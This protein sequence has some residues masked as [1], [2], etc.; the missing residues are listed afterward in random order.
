M[1]SRF[2][3]SF[4]AV[5]AAA[6][7]LCASAP[8]QDS[9]VGPQG[10]LQ[11]LEQWRADRGANWRV[12]VDEGT[13][14][15]EFLFGGSVAREDAPRTEADWFVAAREAL[16]LAGDLHGIESSTLVEHWTQ[17]LPLGMV[18]S[19][20]KM[21][22]RFAQQ[23]DGVPVDGGFVNVLFD[24][25]GTLLS[26]QTRALPAIV[27]MD[28]R[29]ALTG[30]LGA[31]FARTA[32]HAET[33]LDG[34]VVGEPRLVIAQVDDVESRSGVLAW[35]VEVLWEHASG[36][37]Q[38]GVYFIDARSGRVVRHE[39][40][41]HN[42]DISGNVKSLASPGVLPDTGA[43]PESAQNLKYTRVTAGAVTT[44]TDANGNFTLVGVNAPA[45]VT[46]G[47]RG[48]YNNISNSAGATYSLVTTLASATGNNVVLNQPATDLVTSQANINIAVN[49]DRDF[50]RATN[51]T[52][53]KADF[54]HTANANIA[55]TCNAYFN[56]SSIN[57]Y[58]SGGGCV[59][60]A[61]STVISHED[62]HWLNVIYNTGNGSDGMGE[63][64]ADV[65]A[66]YVW[67]NNI[68]GQNFQ[69]SGNHIRN[70]LNT[71]Q[72]CGDANPGCHANGSVHANGEPWMG[73]A[74]K[75]RR[76]LKNSL[77]AAQGRLTS[78]ALF[79]GWMNAYNQTQIKSVIETQWLTLDDDDGNIDNGTPHFGSINSGFVEQ[80]FPGV[81]LVPVAFTGVTSL[82]T[83][84][85]Q[86]G[87]YVVNANIA[88]N[89]GGSI[90]S[91][92]L[93]YRV[94]SAGAYAS[95]PMNNSGGVAY[96]AGIP[97]QP[98]P[99]LVY[100]YLQATDSLGNTA[101][102]PA[103]APASGVPVFGVGSL[104][105][106]F[107]D[108]FD[109]AQGWTVSNTSLTSGAWE[110]GDP[111]GT[112]NTGD[113]AQPE[114]DF[115]GGTGVSC[116]FTDQGSVGGSAGSADVDGGPTQL[117]SP[118]MD[119]NSPAVL[120]QYA[121]WL[122]N[123]T[124]D[125]SLTVAVSGNGGSTWVTARTYTGLTGGWLE[126]TV[127]LGSFIAPSSNV[128]IRFS[129]SDNPNNSITEAAIDD[130]CVI[131]LSGSLCAPVTNYCTG[132]INSQLCVPAMTSSGAP[133]LSSGGPF[134]ISA[135][136]VINQKSSILF[137][138]YA[139]FAAQ[140]QG[141]TLCVQPPLRRTPAVSSGGNVGPD[142]CSGVPVYNFNSVI[143]GGSDPLLNAGASVYT[144]WY[145]RDPAD[146]N[147]VGLSDGLT[148][149]IC[150]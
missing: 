113:Q 148:F 139:P 71:R 34:E 125:D 65:W 4:A 149:Q 58:T 50:V 59:N 79:L 42:F 104:S 98:A 133:S 137:Y 82:S 85:N 33:R 77:G 141:G 15:A 24:A 1:K 107:C 5:A 100:Y 36:E 116:Y 6:L 63:G 75:V 146:P 127:D 39:E 110:R 140:F 56:G 28:T 27:G 30:E 93:R 37:A 43:N 7:L 74:W 122:Y 23:V 53:A 38:G 111:N 78:N 114:T 26:I 60:T 80:G 115:P 45:S 57:F 8:A 105:T 101:T 54:I 84:Q 81:V 138:G 128:R 32:F 102:Y 14:Y 96:S 12:D 119:A 123:S 68:V 118:V 11:A 144:Q 41:V 130:V 52:D 134:N 17:F 13:G 49:A 112:T 91:A 76:N 22:V 143:Q 20:D 51:P 3:Q 90:S 145:Y 16:A 86:A 95:V 73:A 66:M 64:N 70:G 132:K 135:V 40:L 55:D 94:G 124:G 121:Y 35:R 9:S 48:V 89:F 142:D 87:P 92:T 108:N 69:G 61:Y 25:R 147:T 99:S 131:T 10:L 103:S 106:V 120:L 97:G 47:Y 62:G 126:D 72:F 67:D 83:T 46:F 18:G 136:D 88:S 29:P 109:T 21:T 44:N 117:I 150:P 2:A 19:S 129:V 31:D